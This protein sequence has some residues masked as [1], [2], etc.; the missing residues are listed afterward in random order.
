M[1][2]KFAPQALMYMK[3]RSETIE[4]KLSCLKLQRQGTYFHM[5]LFVES[6]LFECF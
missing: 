3:P 5:A 6:R 4:K 2:D 1:L